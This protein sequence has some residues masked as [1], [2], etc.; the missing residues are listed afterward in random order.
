MATPDIPGA[1]RAGLPVDFERLAR[2]GDT[3]LTPEE[4][5]ALKTHG[6][7]AQLQDHVFMIRVRVPG[8]LLH[9]EQARRFVDMGRRHARDWVHITTR[10][11]LE[12]HWVSDR[13]VPAVLAEVESIGLTTRSA[14]G[15]TLRNVMSAEEAGVGLDEPFDCLPDAQAVSAA[16][17]SRSRALNTALPSRINMAF[18]GSPRCRDDALLNDGGFVSVVRDGE[19]G[20]ELWG[21]GSLGRSPHLAVRLHEFVPRDDTLAAAE[22]LVDVFVR[23]GDLDHPAKGRLKYVVE[24]L[25]EKS[26]RAEWSVAFDEARRRPHPDPAPV[27]VLGDA[28]NAAVL[29]AAPAG[30]WS[31]GVRPQ[32]TVGRALVTVDVPMGDLSGRELEAIADLAERYG[33]D[34]LHLSRDQ[35]VVLRDV[36][37][38]SVDALRDAL[39]EHSLGILGDSR[40][41]RV[42]ACT[43]S[44]VCALGIT[45]APDAGISLLASDGLRRHSTLRV[46]VSGCPNSCAQHQAADIGLAGTKVKI[47]GHA[48]DGYQVFVG[49]DLERHQH[50]E[51]VG[52]V[53]ERDVVA[54]VDALVG[55]WEALRHDGETLGRTCR[56]IGID[57]IAA[58]VA[59]LLERRW[60]PGPGD[61]ELQ[62]VTAGSGP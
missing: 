52:R 8:G 55:V 17:V 37:V 60:E 48:L 46:H 29:A 33:D 16:I 12:L 58:H 54:A 3:D 40:S 44:A 61:E 31:A 19:P 32:R 21:G 45:T 2:V 53:G 10:Q 56:R 43:G 7:C 36:S 11:N 35:D 4:R 26:F 49:A 42:R 30:G 1:K 9:P 27:S 24:R 50:G 62:L 22:A 25:G 47:N 6:V 34:A 14:C 23:H 28:E 39:A 5:Y 20:Y 15:H 57:A 41:P 38:D 13:S 51:V 18:G 59:T